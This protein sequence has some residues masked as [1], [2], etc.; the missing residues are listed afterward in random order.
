MRILVSG[1]TGFI[2]SALT[3]SLEG[4]GH[5]GVGLAR[6]EKPG[7]VQWEP[8]RRWIDEDH[9][10]DLDAVI[11]L[12]GESIGGRWTATKKR[13]ILQSR[14]DVTGTLADLVATRHI[15]IFV[16]SSAMGYYGDRGD[17]VLTE[18]SPPGTGFLAE[19]CVAWE[20]AAAPAATAGSRVALL[21]TG[22]VLDPDGGSF[23]PMLLP[24]KLGAGGR[25]GSGDQWWSWISLRDEVEAIRF[26]LEQDV[27]GPV[28]LTSPDPRPNREFVT[29]LGEAMHRPSIM[30]A[31]AFALKALLGGQFAEQVL[32]GSQRVMPAVL[33][34]A[35]FE[36]QDPDLEGA[37][38]SLFSRSA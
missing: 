24:F 19:V 4:A 29:A 30:P 8:S 18:D 3:G 32:L 9:L 10:G 38:A 16:S 13:A 6:S 1:Y 34:G 26:V 35:G 20:E 11:N 33:T 14:L 22:L 37:L 27:A 36:F 15:P 21:R 17:E 28:N 31:P 25:I 2:G 7:A 23:P 12:A 5:E